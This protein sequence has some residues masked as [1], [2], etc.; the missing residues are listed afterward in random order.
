[1]LI[2]KYVYINEKYVYNRVAA[3]VDRGRVFDINYFICAK[4]LKMYSMTSLALNW[5]DVN[6]V[7]RLPRG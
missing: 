2:N 7:K 3:L 5:R 4:H 6:L 1:M